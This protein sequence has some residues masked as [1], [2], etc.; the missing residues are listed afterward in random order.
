MRNGC[1]KAL[2]WMTALCCAASPICAEPASNVRVPPPEYAD[3]IIAPPEWP[4]AEPLHNPL[5]APP[6]LRSYP[7]R[8]YQS[9]PW[10]AAAVPSTPGL[11]GADA[12]A[13][14]GSSGTPAESVSE[15]RAVWGGAKPGFFQRVTAYETW[16]TSG[17]ASSLEMH[18]TSAFITGGV[19][20]FRRDTPLLFTPGFTARFLGGPEQPD[21][22]PRLYDA[23]LEVRHLRQLTERLGMDVAVTPGVYSDFEHSRHAMLRVSGRGLAAWQWRPTTQLVLGVAY[24]NR[25]NLKLLPIGGVIWL[26]NDQWRIEALAPQPR[27]ARRLTLGADREAW[28]YLAGEVGGACGP[29]I[30]RTA[31]ATC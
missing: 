13:A 25:G 27:V 11:A 3:A 1:C 28:A 15:E 4:V 19:P 16:L 26:P 22:P 18:E 7:G 17:G 20:F 9:R 8:P 14:P 21:V 23:T 6:A 30:A 2:G 24:F 12:L 5:G 10:P 29:S 31:A